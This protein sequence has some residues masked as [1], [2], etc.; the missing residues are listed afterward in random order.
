VDAGARHSA[1]GFSAKK[2]S[3]IASE[4]DVWQR[5][6]FRVQQA[7]CDADDVV[8][9]D[10]FGSNLD[11]TRHYARA[12]KGKRVYEDVPRN[13]PRNT[14]TIAALTTKGIG[15]A[16]MLNGSL[17]R[18]ACEG[19]IEHV[20]GPTLRPGQVIVLDNATAHHGGRVEELLAARG[21]RVWYLPP[22]SPD[23]SPIELAFS[24]VKACLRRVKAR[25]AIALEDA[26]AQA[27]ASITAAEA[28]AFFA[29]CGYPQWPIVDQ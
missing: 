25:S 29:H 4:R 10:E 3:L 13:T 21:C 16:L 8:V 26:I 14:T 15:P 12:P 2:K 20:L 24:K 18:A 17:T 23:F 11:S 9:L 7:G 1:I 22:Y 6:L 27:L 28:R 5:V 19:Y